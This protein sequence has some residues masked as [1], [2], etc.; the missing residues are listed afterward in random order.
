M[1]VIKRVLIFTAVVI[2]AASCTTMNQSL[3][4]PS[5]RMEWKK[6]DF[7]YSAQVTGEATTT[8]ILGVDWERLFL[9]KS[10]S[11]DGK[12]LS[13]I[14]VIGLISPIIGSIGSDGTSGYALYDLLQKNPGYDVVFYPQYETKVVKPIGL[15]FIYKITTVKATAKLAKIK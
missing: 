10:A 5:A 8:K 9:K 7:T 12:G 4:E 2:T 15:G 13:G 3:R 6:D 14:P 11:T 1:N